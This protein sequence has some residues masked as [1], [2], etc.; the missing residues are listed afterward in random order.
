MK[1]LAPLD[2]CMLS[3]IISANKRIDAKAADD[4]DYK[5]TQV[6]ALAAQS[7][8]DHLEL[9]LR[10]T[11]KNDKHQTINWIRDNLVKNYPMSE[12]DFNE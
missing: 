3:R 11:T 7:M 8:R 6:L 9:I 4:K 12:N 1:S 2:L 5:T 10:D